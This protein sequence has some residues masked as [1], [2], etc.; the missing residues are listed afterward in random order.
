MN[1]DG[2][3]KRAEVSVTLTMTLNCWP[4]VTVLERGRALASKAAAFWTCTKL[5]AVIVE[6]MAAPTWSKPVAIPEK[7]SR[8]AALAL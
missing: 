8:P 1:G 3:R 7:P 2:A 6:L 5:L 4:K